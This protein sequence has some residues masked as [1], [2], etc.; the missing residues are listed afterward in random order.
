MLNELPTT[1]K[2][3]GA[4]AVAVGPEKNLEEEAGIIED[5]DTGVSVVPG[6]AGVKDAHHHQQHQP[7]GGGCARVSHQGDLV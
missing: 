7:L 3:K 1:E 4:I 5:R 6:F 2:G